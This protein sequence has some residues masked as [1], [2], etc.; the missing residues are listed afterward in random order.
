MFI[1]T[2]PVAPPR[3]AD[4]HGEALQDS[5][6]EVSSFRACHSILNKPILVR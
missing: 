2:T 6:D 4:A 5:P 3:S 1:N